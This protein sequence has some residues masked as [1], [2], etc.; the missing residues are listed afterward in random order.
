[1]AYTMKSKLREWSK[2]RQAD[3]LSVINSK[4]LAALGLTLCSLPAF[5]YQLAEE[6]DL[7]LLDNLPVQALRCN[8]ASRFLPIPKKPSCYLDINKNTYKTIGQIELEILRQIPSHQRVSAWRCEMFEIIKVCKETFFG[9]QHQFE[10]TRKSK[11]TVPLNFLEIAA[12]KSVKSIEDIFSFG[13]KRDFECHWMEENEVTYSKRVCYRNDH[14]LNV[15]GSNVHIEIPNTKGIPLHLGYLMTADGVEYVWNANINISCPLEHFQTELCTVRADL[16]PN[17]PSRDLSNLIIVC[18][19]NHHIFHL[20]QEYRPVG[21]LEVCAT[22][23]S[24]IFYTSEGLM[25]RIFRKNMTEKAFWDLLPVTE[26]MPSLALTLA[27]SMLEF[28]QDNLQISIERIWDSIQN[29]ICTIK[30]NEWFLARSLLGVTPTESAKIFFNEREITASYLRGGL[31]VRNCIKV[32]VYLDSNP[33]RCGKF[34]PIKNSLD[35]L[36]IATNTIS[37][38]TTDDHCS[39]SEG[40]LIY[41]NETHYL[42]LDNHK[43]YILDRPVLSSMSHLVMHPLQFAPSDLYSLHELQEDEFSRYS[44]SKIN[45]RLEALTTTLLNYQMDEIP[46]VINPRD[47]WTPISKFFVGIWHKITSPLPL[48]IITLAILL[49]VAKVIHLIFVWKFRSRYTR[50]GQWRY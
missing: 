11:K 32:R 44:I 9:F 23:T 42:G 49:I 43:L 17:V 47:P 20:N 26:T 25:L 12:L 7:S 28:L 24:R 6:L 46:G 21:P 3:T 31:I 15:T 16:S 5:T 2:T 36:E 30:E 34:W 22:N 37:R 45:K 19:N 29:Q 35:F 4:F 41:I 33:T 14:L 10:F 39:L 18:P 1:M 48:F 50:P 40:H 27:S 13:T 8:G 38:G